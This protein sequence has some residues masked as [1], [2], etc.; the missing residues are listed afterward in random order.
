MDLKTISTD[1]LA[2]EISRRAKEV[3]NAAQAWGHAQA[4]TKAARRAET[5]FRKRYY[6]D[7]ELFRLARAEHNRREE[8]L[9][10]VGR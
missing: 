6:S 9:S 5:P 8:I 10:N 2:D 1:Q 4:D 7:L 3:E